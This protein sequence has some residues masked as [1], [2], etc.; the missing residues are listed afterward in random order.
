MIHQQKQT[1][2]FSLLFLVTLFLAC[3]SP[4]VSKPVFVA[5]DSKVTGLSFTNHLASTDSF[6]LFRY[7]YF[8]NGAGVGAG[9]FNNDG[10]TDIFFC[11][12][13]GDNGLYLNEGNL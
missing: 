12:N 3:S 13:Q 5:L 4:N 10:L 1:L 8:Y 7:M 6:N 11:S 2:F 9:D